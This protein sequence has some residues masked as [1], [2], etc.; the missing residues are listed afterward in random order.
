MNKFYSRITPLFC[1]GLKLHRASFW[2]Y[3]IKPYNPLKLYNI[4]YVSLNKF[5]HATMVVKID[6]HNI[7]FFTKMSISTLLVYMK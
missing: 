2:F 6:K 5:Y 1:A 4:V 7:Q 3:T